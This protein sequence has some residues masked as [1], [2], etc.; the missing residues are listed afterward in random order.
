MNQQVDQP[1]TRGAALASLA[2]LGVVYGDIGTSPLYAFKVAVQAVGAAPGTAAIGIASLILWSLVLVVSI[3]YALLIMRADNRGEGG[4]VA[5]LALLGTRHAAPGSRQAALLVLG[6][7]GASLLYGDG[8]ITPAI[9]VLSAVEGLKS[10]APSLAP[11]VLPITIGILIALFIVQARGT[12]VI[13]RVFGPIMLVWF[14]A[15]AVLG[16]AAIAKAPQVLGALDPAHAAAF[17][18][19]APLAVSFAVLG[20]VFLGVTGGEAM[21]ADM[22]HF[23]RLP[24]RLAWFAIA[25]PALALN[26]LGQAALVTV[27]PANL[28]NSFYALAPTWAHYPLVVFATA[29][30]VIA[31]QAI[32]SGVF[33]LTQ[34][35]IQLG[36][37]PRLSVLHTAADQEG[38]V[39]LPLANWLLAA[40]TLA[41][42]LIFRS[43]DALAGAYGVAVSALMAIS[44]FLA[45]LIARQWGY[46]LAL[47]ILVNGGFFLLDCVFFAANSLKLLQGG[48]FPL[49]IAGLIAF[50]M[51]TW[52]QGV[53]L[54][55]H[56]RAH[57]REDETAFMARLDEAAPCRTKG[58][59]AFLSAAPAG[60]PLS[61][62]EHIRHNRS[63]Q[64]R[65]ILMS[66]TT[67][68][69]P[70]VADDARAK[71]TPIGDG[72]DRV[73]LHYGF[74]E[75][76]DIP[77]ALAIAELADVGELDDV[78]YYLGRET[79][80]ADPKIPGMA[81]WR[82]RL[83]VSM[84]RNTSPTGSSFGIPSVQVVEIGTEVRI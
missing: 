34:Q 47:V 6:L 31:S 56:A 10:D 5:M 32:I 48:W 45:A 60:I 42:V 67:V 57:L 74:M 39:Y 65:V 36:F 66:V 51:L 4:V 82:E 73:E 25:L 24:I 14:A 12:G 77:G 26:Y 52:R 8:A 81:P 29:A 76:L 2:A 15:I 23:G 20:A 37:L 54:V 50:L 59:G 22:G 46:N 7:V 80:I 33:S 16:I 64:K 17:L 83:F 9:S 84:H 43:S 78:S 79:V 70:Q 35:S 27:Q 18:L 68:E 11:A 75:A 1:A 3:K 44:T 38:Q 40:A 71:V 53:L 62:T 55:E 13:G 21:Y 72:V 69:K 49:V 58:T 61:L 28:N 19:H 63:L 41:A 30:T